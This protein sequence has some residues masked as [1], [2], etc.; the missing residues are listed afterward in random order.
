VD[1]QVPSYSL[2]HREVRAWVMYERNILSASL[3]G[4]LHSY[5]D[6]DN[7]FLNG[8]T[9]VYEVVASLGVQANSNLKISGDLDYG[10]N[11][12]FQREVRGL[13]RAE[14]RFGMGSKGGAK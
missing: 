10:A 13:L 6:K 2:S 1:A 5:D 3:D 4:I 14:L 8:K 11:P 7:P 12:L 9:S